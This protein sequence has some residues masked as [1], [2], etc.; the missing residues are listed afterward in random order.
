MINIQLSNYQAIDLHQL[1]KTLV[2][3][4]SEQLSNDVRM[5]MLKNFEDHDGLGAIAAALEREITIVKRSQE[6]KAGF[7]AAGK[8]DGDLGV[9]AGQMYRHFNGDL[10]QVVKV[11]QA[12]NALKEADIFLYNSGSAAVCNPIDAGETIIIFRGKNNAT[13]VRSLSNFLEILGGGTMCYRFSLV[14]GDRK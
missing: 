9:K 11:Q 3:L 4:A 8:E 1:L 14:E 10:F 2:V 6:L 5:S 7:V 13:W 12:P